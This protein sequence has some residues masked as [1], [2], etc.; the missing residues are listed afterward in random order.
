MIEEIAKTET[1]ENN[2]EIIKKIVINYAALIS[3]GGILLYQLGWLYWETY[4]NKLNIDSSFIEIPFEKIIS[5]TWTTIAY[6]LICFYKSIEQVNSLKD[7]DSIY[8][9]DGLFSMLLGLFMLVYIQD[10]NKI[11]NII[12]LSIILFFVFYTIPE[13]FKDKLGTVTKNKFMMIIIVGIYFMSFIFYNLKA[14]NDS[15]A[16]LANYENDIEIM[17]NHN[18]KVITGKFVTFLNDKYFLLIENNKCKREIFIINDN[19]ISL[20]KMLNNGKKATLYD[21]RDDK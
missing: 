20:A 5:T 6:I 17:L 15:K 21:L 2:A 11:F 16:L 14:N 3:I 18:N 1:V 10:I 4:L 8:L 13:K 9:T 7:K 19:E 12:I